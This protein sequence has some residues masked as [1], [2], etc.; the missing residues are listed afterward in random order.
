[1]VEATKGGG[2]ARGICE[3]R[4]EMRLYAAGAGY[5]EVG[6]RVEEEEEEQK[7]VLVPKRPLDGH[8][9]IS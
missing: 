8:V 6:R 7:A 1:L 4:R 9:T 2:G 5:A 3:F